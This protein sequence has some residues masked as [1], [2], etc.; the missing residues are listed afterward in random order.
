MRAVR[1]LPDSPVGVR[2]ARPGRPDRL[3][4]GLTVSRA[5]E[6]LSLLPADIRSDHQ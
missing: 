1:C 5:G 4:G 6:P 2:A 3:C